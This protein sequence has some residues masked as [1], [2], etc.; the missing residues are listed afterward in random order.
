MLSLPPKVVCN[1][2]ILEKM[3]IKESVLHAQEVQNRKRPKRSVSQQRL[4]ELNSQIHA[5]ESLLEFGVY[6]S[7]GTS[8][9]SEIRAF[10]LE[11]PMLLLSH[12]GCLVPGSSC[13]PVLNPGSDTFL[14]V[15]G[16]FAPSSSILQVVIKMY[17]L[18]KAIERPK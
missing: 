14:G 11:I 16:R 7:L 12:R 18:L 3:G 6:L 17:I 2:N 13:S 15:T 5:T 4:K 9:M 8:G 10:S 1:R